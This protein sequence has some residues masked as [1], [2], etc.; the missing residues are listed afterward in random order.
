MESSFLIHPSPDLPTKRV[1]T[2]VCA[3]EPSWPSG[4]KPSSVSMIIRA[5]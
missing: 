2:F 4:G 3:R 5:A 1:A